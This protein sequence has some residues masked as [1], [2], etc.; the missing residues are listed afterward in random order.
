MSRS[1]SRASRSR[2]LALIVLVTLTFAASSMSAAAGHRHGGDQTRGS[3]PPRV[4]TGSTKRAHKTTN[5]PVTTASTSSVCTVPTLNMRV[6]V[7]TAPGDDGVTTL[8]AITSTLDYL[9]TPYDVM[10]ASQISGGLTADKL[11]ADC[12]GFYQAVLLADGE[13]AYTPDGGATWL[14]GLS[15]DEWTVLWNY[16]ATFGVRQVTWYTYPTAAYGFQTPGAIDTTTSPLSTKFTPAGKTAFP[17]INTANALTIANAW[18]YL[19]KPLDSST[20]PWLTD[21]AGNALAAVRTYPDGRQNLA[22]TF[23]SNQFL[24]HN[25]VLGQGVVSWA[26]KGVFLGQRHVYISAQIDDVL[27]DDNT[28]SPDMVCG[29][30]PETSPTTYRITANDMSVLKSWQSRTQQKN[31]TNNLVLDMAFNGYGATADSDYDTGLTKWVQQNEGVFKWISH[32]WDHELL[33]SVTYDF[34]YAEL[35]QNIDIANARP[36]NRR[37]DLGGLSLDSFSKAN[38]VTPE[39][40]GLNNPAFLKAAHD[41]G[42][43][44]LVSDTSKQYPN[45]SPNAGIYN[46]LQPDILMI[47][48]YPTN[49]F[50]NVSTPAEW[51]AEYNCFYGPGGIAPFFS[52][53]QTYSQILDTESEHLLGYMLLGNDNPWMFH[54]TN[55]RAYDGK[56]SLLSDLL[57]RTLAK[58]NALYKLPIV[59]PTMDQ[60]GQIVASR[61]QYN[62]AG[63]SATIQPG[64]SITLTAQS[65]VTIP[66]TGVGGFTSESYGGQR[67][68]YISLRAGQT[69]TIPLR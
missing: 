31:T 66:I 39:I 1:H 18:S 45:P 11:A 63:V 49:L 2:W 48:R 47:P 52:Q 34:A 19:A 32:T 12:N 64:R 14:S 56:H 24:T 42:I 3:G 62:A 5:M 55:L 7:L 8:P 10:T 68:S 6:L 38:L 41:L 54:Q 61:M 22:L 50:Y 17:Y 9:G 57:D 4:D 37:N 28:W 16:E 58:Y 36:K 33:D 27:I 51:V 13:L 29:A 59:S 26:T 44:Y 65:A 60:L 25:T 67:I 53:N 35:K 69:V 20:A 43:R 30:D 21:S 23:D 15:P 46:P 40:S